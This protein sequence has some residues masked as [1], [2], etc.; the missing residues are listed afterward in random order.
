VSHQSNHKIIDGI[1][2]V[3][4][5]PE[6]RRFQSWT[7][8]LC[9]KHHDLSKTAEQGFMYQGVYFRP[10]TL[11]GPQ[12]IGLIPLHHTLHDDAD[13]FLKDKAAIDLDRHLIKQSLF[14]LFFP[15]DDMQ[16]MRDSLPEFLVPIVPEFQGMARQAAP[17]WSIA[18]NPRALRQYREIEPKI[19]MY[20][21]V[22]LVY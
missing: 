22:R 12:P 8:Q 9:R 20:V 4:L 17:L 16:G 2:G 15:C 18:D 5:G 10:S 11:T 7:D 1:M 14:K 3:L 19:E 13:C 6:D 21:A